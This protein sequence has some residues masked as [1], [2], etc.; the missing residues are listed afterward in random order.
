MRLIEIVEL[1]KGPK[2]S[3]VK[4]LIQPFKNPSTPKE[5]SIKRKPFHIYHQTHENKVSGKADPIPSEIPSEKELIVVKKKNEKNI[6]HLVIADM[7]Y[8]PGRKRISSML[9]S[10]WPMIWVATA[11]K[12]KH[13]TSMLLPLIIGVR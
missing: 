11:E 12:S 4:L 8:Y 6:S 5:V 10:S 13:L 2:N 3:K 7:Q 1:I 9:L